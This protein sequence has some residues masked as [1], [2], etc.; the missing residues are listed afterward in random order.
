MGGGEKDSQNDASITFIVRSNT[1]INRIRYKCLCHSSEIRSERDE[2]MANSL[3]LCKSIW[4][5]LRYRLVKYEN[6]FWVCTNERETRKKYTLPEAFN[7]KLRFYFI[8][9]GK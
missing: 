4:D 6:T 2:T 7:G 1:H 3:M 9:Q 5:A 8:A